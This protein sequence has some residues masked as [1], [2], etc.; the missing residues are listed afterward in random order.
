MARARL[1]IV[2]ACSAA[3]TLAHCSEPARHGNGNGDDRA[4]ATVTAKLPPAKGASDPA[5]DPAKPRVAENAARV[6]DTPVPASQISRYTSLDPASCELVEG[7]AD[8]GRSH[9][10][11]AGLA[12]YAVETRASN[13]RQEIA[14]IGPNGSRSELN[15]RRLVK[16]GAANELGKAAEWRGPTNGQPRA[17]IFRLNPGSSAG[18]SPPISNLVVVRLVPSACVVGIVP[19]RPHQNERARAIADG[20][21]P[22]CVKG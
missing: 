2:A 22:S 12:G 4:N 15:L 16:N 3:L 10:R 19:R 18:K 21:M 6:S 13:Q 14:V 5:L 20:E 9:R 7:N 1:T 8:D 17:L 11:C